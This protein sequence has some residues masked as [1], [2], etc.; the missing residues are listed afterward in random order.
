MNFLYRVRNAMARFMCGRNGVDQLTW[1]LLVLELVLSFIAGFVR[2]RE[3]YTVLRLLS[4]ALVVLVFFRVFSRN[5][6]KR[7]AENAKFVCWWGPK[8]VGLRDW[9]YR[10]ADKAHKYVKCRCGA[11]CRVPKGVGKVELI[12]PKC[13]E[14]KVVKT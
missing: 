3:V 8:S 13:G 4:T 14:K 11:W 5:L 6:T 2:V 1:A 7:R 10:H 9:R 12:C